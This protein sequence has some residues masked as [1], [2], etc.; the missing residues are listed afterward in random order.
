[1]FSVL[2]ENL[3]WYL[4]QNIETY[5]TNESESENMEFQESNKMHGTH[6]YTHLNSVCLGHASFSV[7]LYEHMQNSISGIHL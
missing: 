2:D 1:M 7:C 4:N 6:T 3:S 5:D